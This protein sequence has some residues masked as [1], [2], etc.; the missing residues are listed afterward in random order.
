MSYDNAIRYAVRTLKNP[1]AIPV[2]VAELPNGEV[3]LHVDHAAAKR[4]PKLQR[5]SFA[6]YLNDLVNIIEEHGD[7][8]CSVA[9][10]GAYES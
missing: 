3:L 9:M 4:L 10:R 5:A 8:R 6:A 7:V 1:T 2:D